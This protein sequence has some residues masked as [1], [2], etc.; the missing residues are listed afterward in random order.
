M[1][2]ANRFSILMAMFTTT[3][4]VELDDPDAELD[5]SEQTI[6]NGTS[7]SPQSFGVAL[8]TSTTGSTCSATMITNEIALTTAGCGIAGSNA[9]IAGYSSKV[10]NVRV[11]RRASG[12]DAAVVAI[13]LHKP[14][15]LPTRS[16]LS[17]TSFSRSVDKTPLK[18]GDQVTCFGYSG[19]TLRSGRFEVIDGSTS[20]LYKL[21]GRHNTVTGNNWKVSVQDLGGY[22]ERDGGAVVA[23]LSVE[24]GIGE[25]AEAIPVHDLAG[26]LVDMQ[27]AAAASRGGAAIRLR[28]D[29]Q[30]RFLTAMPDVDRV[31][32][33]AAST[34]AGQRD[35]AFY[36][37]K[38]SNPAAAGDWFRLVDARSG[39]CLTTVPASSSLV[40]RPCT[41][42]AEQMFFFGYKVVNGFDRY[43]LLQ[44]FGRRAD[45][46]S[47]P[48]VAMRADDGTGSQRWEMW[49][50]LL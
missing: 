6:V 31:A 10:R 38:V 41:T 23:I 40:Q 47:A 49:L 30:Q 7:Q 50:T 44:P 8:L 21:R 34:D 22:C 27:I 32:A 43:I 24:T 39:R 13:Q 18:Q 9:V 48:S 14:L 4:C 3:A 2:H 26:G 29:E 16:G 46:D 33:A 1:K 11:P 12:N 20:Q 17:T 15:P 5:A 36:L 37:D 35:Q 19:D 28:D 25:I 45:A 42:A